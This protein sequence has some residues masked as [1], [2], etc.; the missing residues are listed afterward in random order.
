MVT[1]E[2]TFADGRKYRPRID[3][4]VSFETMMDAWDPFASVFFSEREVKAILQKYIDAL[5]L[6]FHPDTSGEEYQDYANNKLVFTAEQAAR[7]DNDMARCFELLGE[8]VYD[9]GSEI[10]EEI[11]SKEAGNA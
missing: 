10:F 3:P 4:T 8:R 7:Y 11:M 9:I 6:G 2:F 1:M 5:G